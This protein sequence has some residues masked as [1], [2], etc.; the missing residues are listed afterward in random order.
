MT[1]THTEMYPIDKAEAN[2]N[3]M[4]DSGA[5]TVR[6][7]TPFS[8]DWFDRTSLDVTELVVVFVVYERE[9]HD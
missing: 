8:Y 2:I 1:I 9:I 3:A 7:L 5:W 4:E 6:Q